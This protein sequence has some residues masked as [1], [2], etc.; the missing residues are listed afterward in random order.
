[1]EATP[2]QGVQ[3]RTADGR[4]ATVVSRTTSWY[5]TQL[6]GKEKNVQSSFFAADGQNLPR[7]L[8]S[9][10]KAKTDDSATS[11]GGIYSWKGNKGELN[12]PY[13]TPLPFVVGT[14]GGVTNVITMDAI[15]TTRD[16]PTDLW[17]YDSGTLVKCMVPKAVAEWQP[18][19]G[20]AFRVKKVFVKQGQGPWTQ[21]ILL[22]PV[23][24]KQV[25]N[26]PAIQPHLMD[27]SIRDRQAEADAREADPWKKGAATD[28][29]GAGLRP[30]LEAVP[31]DV[32]ELIVFASENCVGPA[33]PSEQKRVAPGCF[34]ASS[35]VANFGGNL[36]IT[37]GGTTQ[38]EANRAAAVE[39]IACALDHLKGKFN[40]SP[41]FCRLSDEL[42]E[43]ARKARA[44]EPWMDQNLD[45]YLVRV[46]SDRERAALDLY[47]EKCRRLGRT[48][49]VGET[50]VAP[51][52][53]SWDDANKREG[54]GRH[55]RVRLSVELE[56]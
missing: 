43:A 19:K 32:P 18:S 16:H 47:Q 31:V 15:A 29:I 3:I 9:V 24:V 30:R 17:G 54:R 36:R 11:S 52:E 45:R 56:H 42:K 12:Q 26:K 34:L 37:F 38:A 14:N 25:N 13:D 4:V 44:G 7:L 5:L 49:R 53:K 46:L 22:H 41:I 27:F 35:S 10:P 23:T 6:D 40:D 8:A 20:K 33:T 50:L 1:M 48:P 21:A 2:A 39:A 55:S 28:K 51:S